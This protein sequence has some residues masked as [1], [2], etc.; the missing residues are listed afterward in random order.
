MQDMKS[1]DQIATR[2]N[3]RHMNMSSVVEST[4]DIILTT[5][6]ANP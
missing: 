5:R 2:E 6:V 1:K 4:T 3:A